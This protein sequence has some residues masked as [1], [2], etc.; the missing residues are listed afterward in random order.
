MQKK[1]DQQSHCEGGRRACPRCMLTCFSAGG[2]GNLNP[3]NIKTVYFLRSKYL[4]AYKA[5]KQAQYCLAPQPRRALG[6]Q[7]KNKTWH[8]QGFP[9][10]L[11]PSPVLG[12]ILTTNL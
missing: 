9:Y 2:R 5:L 1:M 8:R 10:W 6:G 7:L 12:G 3:H 4:R 11:A